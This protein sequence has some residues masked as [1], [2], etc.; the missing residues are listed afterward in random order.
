MKIKNFIKRNWSYIVAILIP[1]IFVI[2]HSFVNGSWLSGDGTILSGDSGTVYYE[3]YA[4]LWNKV[5]EGG[6][7]FFSWNLGGGID[8]YTAVCNYLISPFTLIALLVP[9]MQ[10]VNAIQC[11]MVLK[12]SCLAFTIM[13]YLQHTRNNRID[14]RKGLIIFLLALAFFLGNSSIW[15]WGCLSPFDVMILFPLYALW[16]EKVQNGEK[17]GLLYIIMLIG[18]LCNWRMMISVSIFLA[19]WYWIQVDRNSCNVAKNMMY[20]FRNIVLAALASSFVIIPCVQTQDIMSDVWKGMTISQYSRHIIMSFVDLVQRFF[21]C[22]TLPIAAEGEPMLYCSITILVLALLYIWI[23]VR[24][25]QKVGVILL[26]VLLLAGLTTGAGNLMWHG[27]IGIQPMVD[28]FAFM[29]AFTL[30]YMAMQVLEY[31]QTIRIRYILGTLAV[32]LA[33]IVYTFFHIV[34]Y[35]D[36]YVYLASVLILVFVSMMILFCRKKSIQYRN[37]LIVFAIV[38][39]GELLTNGYY[40]VREFNMYPMDTL[41]YHK[42]SNVLMQNIELNNGERIMAGQVEPNYGAVE[43]QP[44]FSLQLPYCNGEMKTLCR[45]LGFAVDD[46]SYSS[47]GSSPLINNMFHISYGMAQGDVAVSDADKIAENKGYNLYKMNRL[48]RDGYMAGESVM[49]WNTE[50]A[51][52]FEVQNAFVNSAFGTGNIFDVVTPDVECYSVLGGARYEEE[53]HHGEEG[54][55]HDEDAEVDHS[56][57]YDEKAGYYHYLYKKMYKDDVVE[58]SFV[59]DGESD[60]Y[61]FVSGDQEQYTAVVIDDSIQYTDQLTS[62]QIMLHIGQIA[63]GKTIKIQSYGVMDDLA[64]GNLYY[65]IAKFNESNFA[66][67]YEK[68]QQSVLSFVNK[69][70]NSIEGK[71]SVQE[72]G[73]MVTGIP[74]QKGMSVQVD[75][76]QVDYKTV[77]GALLGVELTKGQHTI[78]ITY[79]TPYVVP[80]LIISVIGLMLALAWCVMDRK[81]KK[82]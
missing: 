44:Y 81:M 32:E 22:D 42:Q 24:R 14:D 37:V 5:H 59:S 61:V 48:S 19:I 72:D 79:G 45:Q 71:I 73:V 33:I 55:E 16:I 29:L 65:R 49:D 75:G 17:S 41:Y 23:P 40:Q 78:T 6:S 67:A 70:D 2:I 47:I 80:A 68:M 13:Y 34:L 38:G 51:S 10:L 25:K 57:Q 54:H 26:C 7:L 60:Y 27:Y 3:L 52:P 9:K 76:R 77:G 69:N 56:C 8:F 1:W 43:D 12:W 21:V 64:D 53:L 74:A 28:G 82:N 58:T 15:M 46:T 4:E 30:I 35:Q 11:I 36:F 18:F 62:K 31:L 66:K 20:Y 63:K 39:I 50:S